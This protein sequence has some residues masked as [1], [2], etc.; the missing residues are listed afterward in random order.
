METKISANNS[1]SF[2]KVIV[3]PRAEKAFNQFKQRNHKGDKLQR[4]IFEKFYANIVE[5][6]EGNPIDIVI[7]YIN[8]GRSKTKKLVLSIS[9]GK[10]KI[11]TPQKLTSG[12]SKNRPNI[13]YYGDEYDKST[14]GMPKYLMQLDHSARL[15]KASEEV[16][17]QSKNLMSH[18]FYDS[19]F[20]RK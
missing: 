7:D 8:F 17:K 3:R 10:N 9:K 11:T 4:D 13:V 15:L 20:F 12:F 14:K 5:E 19:A 1:P 6:H 16:S 2:Q 18:T